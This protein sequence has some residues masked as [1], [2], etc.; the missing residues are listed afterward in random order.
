MWQ[1]HIS[2][3]EDPTPQRT[4]EYTSLTSRS[5]ARSVAT[6]TAYRYGIIDKARNVLSF[7]NHVTAK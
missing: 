2:R 1:R 4:L 6:V 5:L 7:E 3:L